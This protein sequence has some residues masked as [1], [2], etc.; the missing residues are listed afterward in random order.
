MQAVLKKTEVDSSPSWEALWSFKQPARQS[1]S[2]LKYDNHQKHKKSALLQGCSSQAQSGM[3]TFEHITMLFTGSSEVP[4]FVRNALKVCG[5]VS[6]YNGIQKSPEMLWLAR[7]QQ[8]LV[9]AKSKLCVLQA[10][11]EC[12]SEQKGAQ[13]SLASQLPSHQHSAVLSDVKC[14]AH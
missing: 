8:N 3:H 1:W 11:R 12:T 2:H 4:P 13:L 14:K 6:G 5:F 7:M 9:K 10:Q